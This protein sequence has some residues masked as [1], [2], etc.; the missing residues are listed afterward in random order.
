MIIIKKHYD[1]VRPIKL[2]K[3][4]LMQVFV[5]I[6]RN[7]KDSVLASDNPEKSITVK[8]I[9]AGKNKCKIE[10]SDNGV[11]I[12]AKNLKFIFIELMTSDKNSNNKN[13]INNK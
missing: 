10:I 7:A 3:I 13:I 5:N 1:P 6:F 8:K 12:S 4:K 11:G 9:N 2:D